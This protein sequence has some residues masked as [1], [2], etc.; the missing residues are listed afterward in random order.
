MESNPFPPAT[1][2][3]TEVVKESPVNG[4]ENHSSEKVQSDLCLKALKPGVRTTTVKFNAQVCHRVVQKLEES[5]YQVTYTTTYMSEGKKHVSTLYITN[6]S[7]KDSVN[8]L[9]EVIGGGNSFSDKDLEKR[10]MYAFS[11]FIKP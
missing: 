4:D 8:T 9:F 2:P 7:V 10:F 6:P 3:K 5:G 1:P 11:S